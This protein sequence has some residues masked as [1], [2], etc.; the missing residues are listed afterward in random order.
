LQERLP[1]GAAAVLINRSHTFRDL[2]MPIDAAEKRLF[3]AVDG[4]RTVGQIADG[5]SPKMAHNFFD[6]LAWWDQVVFDQSST[7][8][9]R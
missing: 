5:V 9:T 3:D 4:T 6:R 2:V 1:P 7:Q 8:R